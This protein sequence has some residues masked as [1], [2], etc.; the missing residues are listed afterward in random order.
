VADHD[1]DGIPELRVEFPRAALDLALPT[2]D[3][4]NVVLTGRFGDALLHGADVIQVRRGRIRAPAASAVLEPARSTSVLYDLDT[5]AQ[6]VALYASYDGGATWS[7]EVPQAAPTGSLTWNVPNRVATGARVAVVE[8]ESGAP[9]AEEI[10]GVLGVSDPF[11]IQ[12]PL[13]V[14]ATPSELAL[15]PVLP[16]PSRASARIG[17]TLPEPTTVE[18]AVLD[19]QGRSLALLASGSW[20][21]GR[22]EVAWTGRDAR[23]RALRSGLYFARLSAGARVLVRRIVWLE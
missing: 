19:A 16:T 8:A 4:V 20:P 6:W 18:I 17:F 15:A 22:H 12:G 13:D 5:G 11:D 21:A 2:G 7:A 1:H 9:G 23:G 14:A 10:T 3:A